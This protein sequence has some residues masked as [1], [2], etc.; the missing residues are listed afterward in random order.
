M[1]K[2][3]LDSSHGALTIDITELNRIC[4]I[5]LMRTYGIAQENLLKSVIAYMGKR[6]DIFICVTDSLCCMP[7]MNTTL[8]VNHILQ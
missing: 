3:C 8:E 4:G 5:L 1:V 2:Q 7:E 6:M